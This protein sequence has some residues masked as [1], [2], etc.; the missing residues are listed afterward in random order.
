MAIDETTASKR[1]SA[2]SGSVRSCSTKLDALVAG[3][4]LARGVEHERREVETQAEHRGALGLQEGQQT[5]V[6]GAEV[7]DARGPARHVVEQDA[8]SLGAVAVLVG[9]PE[10]AADVLGGR[11]LRCGH[12]LTLRTRARRV[13]ACAPRPAGTPRPPAGPAVRLDGTVPSAVTYR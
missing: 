3:E 5:A 9:A 8:L 12:A 2:G 13:G 11:P 6:A 1:P 10:I 4:A 7:E